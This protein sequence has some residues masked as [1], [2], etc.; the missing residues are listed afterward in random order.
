MTRTSL[1][2]N[3]TAHP[4]IVY[5]LFRWADEQTFCGRSLPV[6][7][8]SAN[9]CRRASDVAGAGEDVLSTECP[10]LSRGSTDLAD[11]MRSC[12]PAS[13]L[14][15]ERNITLYIWRQ[16]S[17]F[18]T[19]WTHTALPSAIQTPAN[20]L[21][22]QLNITTVLE[23]THVARNG[24]GHHRPSNCLLAPNKFIWQTFLTSFATN[25]PWKCHNWGHKQK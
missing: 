7:V 16:Y 24:H 1:E 13:G 22:D 2:D 5:L 15:R 25:I 20:I 18:I 19:T 6:I 4:T 8:S 17:S 21:Y 12:C 9:L 11:Q 10:A 14:R 3:N 23:V